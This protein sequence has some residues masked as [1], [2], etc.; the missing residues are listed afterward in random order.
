[1]FNKRLKYRNAVSLGKNYHRFHPAGIEAKRAAEAAKRAKKEARDEKAALDELSST[2]ED[3][4]EEEEKPERRA[5]L[6]STPGTAHTAGSSSGG[7]KAIKQKRAD[8]DSDSD[9]SDTSD[10]STDDDSSP[11]AS[12]QFSSATGVDAPIQAWEKPDDRS[13]AH[14]RRCRHVCGCKSLT[15]D[16]REFVNNQAVM[17]RGSRRNHEVNQNL[18]PGCRQA[19]KACERLLGPLKEK[20]G[21]GLGGLGD[22]ESGGAVKEEGMD[23]DGDEDDED[24]LSKESKKKKRKRDNNGGLHNG[25]HGKEEAK[26]ELK[27]ADDPHDMNPF[28]FSTSPFVTSQPPVSNPAAVHISNLLAQLE[29]M[30]HTVL[31]VQSAQQSAGGSY[32]EMYERLLEKSTKQEEEIA[33]L[34]MEIARL[35]GVKR[36]EGGEPHSELSVGDEKQP[37]QQQQVDQQ[38]HHSQQAD[39]GVSDLQPGSGVDVA[40][41]SAEQQ[42]YSPQPGQLMEQQPSPIHSISVD[43]SAVHVKQDLGQHMPME[44]Q[45]AS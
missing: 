12:P 8:S 32:V 17:V 26:A 24:E 3:E 9:S 7:G 34:K 1:M 25:Q 23:M 11:P 42:R 14:F 45:E 39:D 37:Q 20:K 27:S 38:R 6:Q 4:S 43:N 40:L 13:I 16:G 31:L 22:D 2:S 28:V 30:T 36:E 21:K 33:E 5:Q 15:A 29:S 41:E 18:H 10:E 44:T 19:G 35:T